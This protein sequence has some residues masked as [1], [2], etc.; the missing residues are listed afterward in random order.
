VLCEHVQQGLE[1][2][3]YD[4][5]R[6]GMGYP[7]VCQVTWCRIH[8]CHTGPDAARLESAAHDAGRYD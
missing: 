3:A 7:L 2:A 1:S 4:G 5:G 6:W 8:S